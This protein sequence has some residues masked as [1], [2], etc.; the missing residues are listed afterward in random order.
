MAKGMAAGN[1]RAAADAAKGDILVT[2]KPDKLDSQ[3]VFPM[4]AYEHGPE[5]MDWLARAFGF[6]ECTRMVQQGRLVHGEM[7]TGSGIVMLATP[8]HDYEGPR[9][10]QQHCNAARAWSTVPWV[11]D[12]VVVYVN[13]INAHYERAKQAG[14]MILSSIE[15]GPPGRRYRVE[16]LEGHKWM[17]VE[18]PS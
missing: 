8:T 3:G 11:I 7:D 17:F 10:H 15:D 13:N 5:A 16:D 12:G 9:R 2:K 18:R 14:A 6:I 4:I 1:I